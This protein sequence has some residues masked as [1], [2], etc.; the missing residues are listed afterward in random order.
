MDKERILAQL[1]DLSHRLGAPERDF[2]VLGEGNTSARCSEDSF[3]VKASGV[4]LGTSSPSGFIEVSFG[5]ILPLLDRERVS[6][7]EV[8]EALFGARVTPG[9]E[10]PSVETLFHAFLLTLDG[11][12]FVGHTH[13][14]S[15][16]SIL[17]ARHGR[18]ALRGRLFPDEIVV[19]GPAP[20]YVEYVDPGIP[21]AQA[22][23]DGVRRHQQDYGATPKAV[24]VENHGLIALGATPDE[25]LAI[26][27]MWDKTA[28]V[29]AGT[30]A[31]GGPRYLSGENVDRIHTR[32]DE[33]CRQDLIT[34]RPR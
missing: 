6:D 13:P 31:F 4:N 24:L 12:S 11:V 33:K 7:D 34:G 8:R 32:P 2:V 20:V 30:Y 17:C 15:V 29:L 10:R 25:A 19:C 27:I 21:L 23:R 3:L 22:I 9:P 28:R 18:E 16:N 1:V 5:R 14:T 26:T